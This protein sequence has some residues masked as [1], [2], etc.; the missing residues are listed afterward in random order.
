M[1][2]DNM[3]RLAPTTALSRMPDISVRTSSSPGE[4]W[5]GGVSHWAMCVTRQDGGYSKMVAVDDVKS[6]L[7]RL[8]VLFRLL[9]CP[10]FVSSCF[11]SSSRHFHRAPLAILHKLSIF[12]KR[13]RA[14]EIDVS[15]LG[16][17]RHTFQLLRE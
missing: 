6:C 13:I 16:V 4:R 10:V 9:L 17:N 14:T 3:T 8:E 12:L 7:K 1:F 5:G 2:T 15:K 11:H